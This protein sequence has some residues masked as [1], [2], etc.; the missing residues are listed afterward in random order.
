[1]NAHDEKDDF[2]TGSIE[3]G[4]FSVEEKK[5]GNNNDIDTQPSPIKI[6]F[7]INEVGIDGKALKKVGAIV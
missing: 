4:H 1:M 7:K 6:K 3:L 5:T 2:W